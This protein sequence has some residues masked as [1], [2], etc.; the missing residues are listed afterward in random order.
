MSAA[1]TITNLGYIPDGDQT[2]GFALSGNGTTVVGQAENS[3]TLVPRAFRWTAGTG[4][5]DIG[6]G[7]NTMQASAIG[8][9]GD[10]SV[11]VGAYGGSLN[12]AFRWTAATGVVDL[13]FLP[14]GNLS[15]A[16][17][18]NTNG[19]VVVGLANDDTTLRSFRWTAATGIQALPSAP[20]FDFSYG[21]SGT[22]A[23]GSVIVGTNANKDGVESADRAY[24]YTDAGG[25][26]DL[27]VQSGFTRSVARAVSGDGQTVVGFSQ[28]FPPPSGF[29][30]IA[31]AYRWTQST[32]LVPLFFDDEDTSYASAVNY[33]GSRIV[34]TSTGATGSRAVMWT[35]TLGSF[36]LNSYLPT[37][38]VNL[39]GWNLTDAD[40]ISYDGSVISG[41]GTF[42]GENAAWIVSGIAVPEPSTLLMAA[43][44]G[45]ALIVAQLL[46]VGARKKISIPRSR[47]TVPPLL[48]HCPL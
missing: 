29:G 31:G 17:G 23:D 30:T 27:G 40:G 48:S 5:Q 33:D 46:T 44:G 13:G 42:N 24:R 11:V 2:F 36:D 28:L 18:V 38:G 16:N 4:A 6:P 7:D 37:L 12:Q 39:T 32:G 41:N 34:G 15:I 19:S 3:V 21:A 8:V 26:Q 43:L 10:G 1:P 25:Y 35:S 20:G 47:G 22:S 9:N 14:G 45:I